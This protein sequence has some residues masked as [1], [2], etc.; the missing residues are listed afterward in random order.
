M[1]GLTILGGIALYWWL[2]STIVG[3]V[4]A[5]TQ[6]LSKKRIALAIFILIPIWDI[7]LG[8]PI[9]AYLCMT[10]SGVKIYKTVDNVEGF[11]VGES[12]GISIANQLTAKDQS[13][14]F[15]DYK[16]KAN[17]KYY[18]SY[19]IENNTSENCISYGEYKYADYA[20]AFRHGRCVTKEEIHESE[21]SRWE[22]NGYKIGSETSMPIFNIDK[23]I[24]FKFTDRK[25]NV[26]L[27]ELV[28]YSWGGGWVRDSLRY[29]IRISGFGCSGIGTTRYEELY[30]KI[31]KP[32]KGEK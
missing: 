30:I 29:F 8:F 6:S 18:K 32:K 15:I 1:I 14:H 2:A 9:Y 11:Y 19:W 4:F 17:G 28:E 13:Y 24:S 10:Q 27:G 21:V 23:V 7:I 20:E 3:K 12:E 26:V 31:L 16:D 5:K 25:S 22:L